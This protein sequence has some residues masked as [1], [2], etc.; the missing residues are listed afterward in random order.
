MIKERVHNKLEAEILI[1]ESLRDFDFD[2]YDGT[3]FYTHDGDF[4]FTCYIRPDGSYDMMFEDGSCYNRDV[5]KS[6]SNPASKKKKPTRRKNNPHK[7]ETHYEI[8]IHDVDAYQVLQFSD[9]DEAIEGADRLS[10][11]FS[12]QGLSLLVCLW[13][14]IRYIET[15]DDG[16]YIGETRDEEEMDY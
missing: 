2:K 13:K 6:S 7:A 4:L 9:R 10:S 1:K 14:V 16:E 8:T 11:F 12:K 15:D 5:R 3:K